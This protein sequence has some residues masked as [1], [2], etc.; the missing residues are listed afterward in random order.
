M[1][2]KCSLSGLGGICCG[3]NRGMT[4]IVNL[5]ECQQNI[6]VH[7]SSCHISKSNLKEYELLLLR[8]GLFNV[9]EEQSKNITVCPNHRNNLGRF[10]RPL[11]S[12]QYPEHSGPIRQCKGRDVFNVQLSQTVFKIYGKLV[13]IGSREYF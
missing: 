5:N 11:R 7:L 10:W 12:C 2:G 6:Q 3:E 9:T 8:A 4:N 1:D 13:Q